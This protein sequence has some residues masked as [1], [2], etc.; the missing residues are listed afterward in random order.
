MRRS[1]F[2]KRGSERSGSKL[3]LTR[4]KARSPFAGGVGALQLSERLV[5]LAELRVDHREMVAERLGVPPKTG[6]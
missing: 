5:V 2:W 1:R 6:T 4:R 3:G